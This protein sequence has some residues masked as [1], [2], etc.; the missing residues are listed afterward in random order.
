MPSTR[1]KAATGKI[2][3]YVLRQ[4]LNG[5]AD[6]QRGE[7]TVDGNR[8]ETLLITPDG[9]DRATIVLLHEGLGSVALWKDFP[10][11]LAV[12]TRRRVFVYSRYGHGNSARLTARREVNYMHHEGEVVLPAVLEQAGIEQPVLLG[13]SDGGSIAIIFAGK[14]PTA[15]QALILEAPH[16]FVEDLSVESIARAR[17]MYQTTDLPRRLGRYHT[18]VDEMF[19][20][21]ND[22]W[23][24]PRFRSWNIEDYL[25]TI[26]C[27]VLLIQGQED[28]YGTRRQLDAIARRV[29]ETQTVLLPQCGHSPHR[30]QPD[31]VLDRI[32]AFLASL[33]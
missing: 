3:R 17:T 21:W 19:W 30:D 6:M 22:I 31:S 11:R 13:H 26:R 5:I 28:E 9:S 15:A 4:G 7:V 20:G 16:V 23:L 14:Y 8:L 2:R 24:D 10:T 32:E 25:D 1:S 18:H 27:P 12:R 33:N 29:A